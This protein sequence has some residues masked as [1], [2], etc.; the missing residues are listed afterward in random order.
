MSSITLIDFL[1]IPASSVHKHKNRVAVV[2]NLTSVHYMSKMITRNQLPAQR[3]PKLTL[4]L[5]G[6][7]PLRTETRTFGG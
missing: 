2:K 7:F 4:R 5:S 1:S 3:T 6:A